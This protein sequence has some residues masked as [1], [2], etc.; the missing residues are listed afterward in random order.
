MTPKTSLVRIAALLLFTAMINSCNKMSNEQIPQP[1]HA[2]V[3]QEPSNAGTATILGNKMENPYTV[4]NIRRAVVSL[5]S[6][7]NGSRTNAV[8]ANSVIT[9]THKYLRFK[10]ASTEDVTRLELLGYE[11]SDVPFDSE[12][13]Y[14]GDWYQDPAIPAD[15]PTY[16]YTVL[17]IDEPLPNGIMVTKLADLYLFTEE[18][19]DT[20]DGDTQD[21]DPWEPDP[22]PWDRYTGPCYDASGMPYDCG[23]NYR[24]V[25]SAIRK[26]TEN[27]K[28]AGISPFDLYNEAMRITGNE[29]ETLTQEV[30]TNSRKYKPAGIIRVQDN[31]IGMDLPLRGVTV[32][33][34]RWFNLVNTTT[35]ANGRFQV[36]RSYR[37]KATVLVKMKSGA[38]SVRGINGALKVW[39]YVFPIKKNIG[40]YSSTGMENISY[41]FSYNSNAGSTEAMTWAGASA[42][43]SLWDMYQYCQAD[44]IAVPPARLS[45][46]LSSAVTNNAST[47]MLGYIGAPSLVTQVVDRFF[48]NARFQVTTEIKKIVQ[49]IL[50][51]VTYRYTT[52]N[53]LTQ[54]SQEVNN[55][56][57]HELAHSVH[58][59]QAG[60]DFWNKYIT[61]VV[62]N[63]GYGEKT[64]SGSG[65]IAISEAWAY[66]IGNT[67]AARK[68][69]A[70]NWNSSAD[71]FTKQLEFETPVDNVDFILNSDNTSRGWI[72]A[73]MFHDMMDNGEPLA[74][75][76]IDNASNFTIRQLYN[77]MTISVSSV[78]DFR[79]AVLSN[80]GN[81]QS[82]QVNQLVSSYRY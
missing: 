65:R 78:Q 23:L 6:K 56:L 47:P 10:P 57:F 14:L 53:G 69:R 79:S 58:Y 62:L 81:V 18:N 82:T 31:T 20:Y 67:Y 36:N 70:L 44:G 75:G 19:T 68:Y 45:I 33:T 52:S 17:P 80:N 11:L 63:N 77:G 74:T 60:T 42:M 51:D 12:I 43:N 26:A 2:S 73:G 48:S 9:A 38:A 8:V 21:A 39:Q 66:F 29:D 13:E 71:A 41:T 30:I 7:S 1:D 55:V 40:L 37:K 50:P 54:S 46:W 49:S 32:K 22:N 3:T 15:Q 72:P 76:V 59:R 27:L 4:E 28:H 5:Q 25:N 35:D 64:T 24:K 16:L 61:Y 34:R